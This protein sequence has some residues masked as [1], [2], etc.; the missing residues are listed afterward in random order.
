MEPFHRHPV[1]RDG[2]GLDGFGY[3]LINTFLILWL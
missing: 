2:H 1:L 3:K